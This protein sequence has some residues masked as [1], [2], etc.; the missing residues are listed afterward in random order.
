[1]GE[2][3]I[4]I[5]GAVIGSVIGAFAFSRYSKIPFGDILDIGGPGLIIRAG[6]RAM[7]QLCES[8]E[9][10]GNLITNESLQ[11]F[12]YGVYIEE[13]GEWH[14]ATFFY[15]STRNLLVFAVLLWYFKRAK[16][17]GNVFT[18]PGAVRRWP[19]LH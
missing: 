6:H 12:P 19:R 15:G 1:M 7:G 9:A 8:Q 18:V 13:L 17:R 16:R 11:W 14:Q 4:A 3:G 5:Y 2:G 10:F